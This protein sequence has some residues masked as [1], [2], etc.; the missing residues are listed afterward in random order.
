[1]GRSCISDSRGGSPLT[2]GSSS[3]PWLIIYYWKAIAFHPC[4][5]KMF[6]LSFDL[7][8]DGLLTHKKLN[9]RL[10][11]IPSN[12]PG[13]ENWKKKISAYETLLG[14]QITDNP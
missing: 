6:H 10:T 8:E 2:L 13:K 4:Y 11:A 12:K 3:L 9:H 1:M 5:L 14:R 7:Q